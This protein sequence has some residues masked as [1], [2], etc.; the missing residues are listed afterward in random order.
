MVIDLGPNQ[1]LEWLANHMGHT[2]PVH[3]NYYRLQERT[4]ELAKVSK[5]LLAVDEGR[6]HNYAGKT[7]DE[8][9]FHL[10][11]SAMHIPNLFNLVIYYQTFQL[12]ICLSEYECQYN[13]C[14]Y[15]IVIIPF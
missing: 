7:L 3:R 2:L 12:S 5:L 10:S 15:L 1:E 14:F 13:D 8:I 6:C 4:L 11:R 9:K